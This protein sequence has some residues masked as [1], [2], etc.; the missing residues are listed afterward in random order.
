RLCTI[1][2]LWSTT[3]RARNESSR[4][5]GRSVTSQ[6]VI[7]LRALIPTVLED[8]LDGHPEHST[9]AKGQ[10]HRPAP[11]TVVPKALSRLFDAWGLA[12]IQ[13][14]SVRPA[15]NLALA[16]GRRDADRTKEDSHGRPSTP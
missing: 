8:L 9:D 14:L 3:S 10:R 13:A 11:T 5:P 6:R 16:R 15:P 2:T 1:H 4:N 12:C 7:T